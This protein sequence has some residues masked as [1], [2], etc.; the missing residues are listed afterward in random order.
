MTEMTE[1]AVPIVLGPT[2]V[3]K[4]ELVHRAAK[5]IG[6]E[7]ISADSRAIYKGMNIGTATPPESLREELR[8][9]LINFLDPRSATAPP[10]TA[11]RRRK[12]SPR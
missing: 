9:H 12:R 2:A 5:A 7:V 6:G 1:R 8:Y 4:T 3:G 11:G 10:I